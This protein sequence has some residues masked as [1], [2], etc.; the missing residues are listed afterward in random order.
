M[1]RNKYLKN[2]A[3]M[4]NFRKKTGLASITECRFVTRKEIAELVPRA[5]VSEIAAHLASLGLDW[6]DHTIEGYLADRRKIWHRAS[7]DCVFK[8]HIRPVVA[9]M[10]SGTEWAS[11]EF[12]PERSGFGDDCMPKL[13]FRPLH[14]SDAMEMISRRGLVL[15]FES[16]DGIVY[17][18]PD[19]RF[20]KQF[21]GAD[22]SRADA[23]DPYTPTID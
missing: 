10:A 9:G 15:S 2:E 21:K 23:L 8:Y 17:E 20:R 3:R 12:N 13:S 16:P 7:G 6:G 1:G 19:G 22:L 11:V 5:M 14:R 4:V 18:S